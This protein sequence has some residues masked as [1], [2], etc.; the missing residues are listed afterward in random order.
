MPKAVRGVLLQCD[1]PQMAM[2]LK[3]NKESNNGY[4]I[5]EIDDRTCLVKENKVDELKRNVKLLMD[6]AMGADDND[7]EPD[8]DSDLD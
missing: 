4:V 7:E 5:E 2:I 6:H 3:L 8:R 1:P